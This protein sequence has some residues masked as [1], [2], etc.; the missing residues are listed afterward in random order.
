MASFAR[1]GVGVSVVGD[2][3]PAGQRIAAV[4]RT[5]FVKK[6]DGNWCLKGGETE[7]QECKQEFDPKKLTSAVRTIAAGEQ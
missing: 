4:V 7:E 6:S 2:A 5:L 3:V 1:S